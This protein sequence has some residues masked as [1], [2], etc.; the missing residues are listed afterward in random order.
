VAAKS[1]PQVNVTAERDPTQVVE[2]LW[3][4]GRGPWGMLPALTSVGDANIWLIRGE[5]FDVLV[6]VGG[7]PSLAPLEGRIRQ[8]GGDP[9]RVREIWL[10]HSHY[11]HTCNAAR[12]LAKYPRARCVMSATAAEF[13]RRRDL[14]LTGM[15][16]FPGLKY[17]IPR[18][19][20]AVRT[21]NVLECPP[22]RFRAVELPGH[23]PDCVG[24]RGLIAG[25]DAMFTGDAIIGDQGAVRGSIGWLDG[26][27]LSDVRVYQRTLQKVAGDPPGLILPGHG[28]PHYGPAAKR[29]LR[30][31][32][33]RI[34][35]LLAIP[36]L[37]SMMPLFPPDA[38]VAD[39]K[40]K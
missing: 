13:F 26:L 11:D 22:Y 16:M 31:C 4:V 8:A 21:G 14:R 27:W 29:S 1:K 36:N 38:E 33:R 19:L 7:G 37:P 18:R 25:V 30:N 39:W 17:Q 35:K 32:V 10:T 34:G 40:K 5:K 28:V 6:D 24:F 9:R 23:T 15:A 20:S 3:W 2:G 12:W